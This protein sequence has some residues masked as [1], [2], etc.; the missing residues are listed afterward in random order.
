MPKSGY[1][2]GSDLLLF[3]KGKAFGHASSHTLTF[4]SETKD[5]AVKAV[6]S[7]PASA[8][9]WKSKGVTGLSVSISADGL[10]CYDESESGYKTLLRAW[11]AGEPVEVKALERGSDT[12]P[13][14]IGNFVISSLEESAQAEDDATYSTSLENDGEVEIDPDNITENNENAAE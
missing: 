13:Y 4:N 10:R 7:A 1:I 14:V 6:A 11:K 9:K 8:S 12:K 5:R 2:N 3:I